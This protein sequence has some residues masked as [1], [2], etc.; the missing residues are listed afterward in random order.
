MADKLAEYSTATGASA[1]PAP[2]GA[3]GATRQSFLTRPSPGSAGME[4]PLFNSPT[5]RTRALASRKRAQR[6]PV[7]P[8][9]RRGGHPDPESEAKL[10]ALQAS[11]ARLEAA[12]LKQQSHFASRFDRLEKLLMSNSSST[13]SNSTPQVDTATSQHTTGTVQYH[14]PDYDGMMDDDALANP[15]RHTERTLPP[16]LTLTLSRSLYLA[17]IG[18]RARSPVHQG[19]KGE[20][21][22]WLSSSRLYRVVSPTLGARVPTR[23][24]MY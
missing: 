15:V 13:G 23:Y 24:F 20:S 1:T 6:G 3:G 9:S 21:P 4:S 11:Q 16:C 18:T 17:S 10:A 22:S 8:T 19:Y 7:Q 5:A 14:H 2:I 12:F